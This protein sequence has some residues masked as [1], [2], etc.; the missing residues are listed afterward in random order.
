MK[1]ETLIEE[2][3]KLPQDQKLMVKAFVLAE[4]QNGS[5]PKTEQPTLYELFSQ[6][7]FAKLDFEVPEP[8]RSPVRP[9]EL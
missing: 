7:P 1:V 6:S 9:V 2:I 5:L 8:V 4:V 3:R